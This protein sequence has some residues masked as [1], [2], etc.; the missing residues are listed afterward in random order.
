MLPRSAGAGK[1][2]RSLCT[3]LCPDFGALPGGRAG[4]APEHPQYHWTPPA[5][6]PRE[7]PM[8]SRGVR[9]GPTTAQSESV[10]NQQDHDH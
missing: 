3:D 8:N 5:G 4:L 6:A 10:V 7:H 1:Q 9:R 2:I